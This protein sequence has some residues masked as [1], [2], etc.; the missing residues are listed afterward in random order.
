MRSRK[1]VIAGGTGFLG[2]LLS[3]HFSSL[4]FEVIILSRRNELN[5]NQKRFVKWD[6]ESLGY[7]VGELESAELLINLTGR[8]VDCRY[9]SQ[10]KEAIYDSR[11]NSTHILGIACLSLK[12]PPKVWINAGSAT[13]YRHSEDRAMDEDTGD[14]GDGFSVDVCKKW[15]AMFYSFNLPSTRMI[16][17]RIGIVLGKNGGALKPLQKLTSL[18]LG[19]IQGSGE[20]YFSWIHEKDFVAVVEMIHA[21]DS[22]AG[23]FNVT[24]PN[25]IQ[26]KELMKHLRR[27]VRVRIGIPSPCWL[28][29]IGAWLIGTETELLLKSRW[30]VPKRLLSLGLTFQFP[31]IGIALEDLIPNSPKS[32]HSS[33]LYNS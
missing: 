2:S 31:T 11:I 6:A 28:L 33:E 4:G 5:T 26:N 24:S 29:K 30:V 25:P 27:N 32:N 19:G 20:Q 7:W 9:N 23:T 16:A 12:N 17:L 10:N 18:G 21:H 1:I 13:I 3:D 15:E 22:I 8:S 14:F